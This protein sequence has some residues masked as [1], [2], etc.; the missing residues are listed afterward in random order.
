MNVSKP[1]PCARWAKKLA[2]MHPADLS[3]VER[4]KLSKHVASCAACA[5]VF[6]DYHKMDI[7]MRRALIIERPLQMRETLALNKVETPP[8]INLM[9]DKQSEMDQ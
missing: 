6:N 7:L 5:I 8:L 3:P 2:A 1:V 9:P 4:A